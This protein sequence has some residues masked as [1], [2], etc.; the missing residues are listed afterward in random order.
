MEAERARAVAD[1]EQKLGVEKVAIKEELQHLRDKSRLDALEAKQV[2]D[3]KLAESAE[4]ME[5]E[6]NKMANRISELE[7][8]LSSQGDVM[9]LNHSEKMSAIK[10]EHER[11][12]RVVEEKM[13]QLETGHLEMVGSLK[14]QHS[15]EMNELRREC[16]RQVEMARASSM[17]FEEAFRDATTRHNEEM[18]KVKSE[19]RERESAYDAHF[20]R[21][22][23]AQKEAPPPPPSYPPPGSVFGSLHLS[24]LE[25]SGVDLVLSD[26]GDGASPAPSVSRPHQASAFHSVPAPAASEPPPPPRDP[27]TTFGGE[28]RLSVSPLNPPGIEPGNRS[29]AGK[30]DSVS[31][32]WPDEVIADAA[33]PV[34]AAAS[35][36]N[37]IS[38]K[39]DKGETA[40]DL[41]DEETLSEGESA[42]AAAA[43]TWAR[44]QT[45]MQSEFASSASL[46]DDSASG[47]D[48][49]SYTTL[50]DQYLNNTKPKQPVTRHHQQQQQ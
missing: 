13:K 35:D 25:S 42:S 39:L 15:E 28:G 22:L 18:Q 41:N 40:V 31:P 9:T 47:N 36:P 37:R 38:P 8:Q 4:Q 3:A 10:L 32:F 44:I 19:M 2:I 6:K 16:L 33:A 7:S 5:K 20:E 43:S 23:A 50:L 48:K 46:D 17:Q 12:M 49:K 26:A 27:K 21:L 29:L 11:S 34:N 1:V 14:D 45:I 24:G 30:V